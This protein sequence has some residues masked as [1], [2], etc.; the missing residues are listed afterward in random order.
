M[1]AL[2]VRLWDLDARSLWLDE[3]I[4]YWVATAPLAQLPAVVRDV[5]QD[6]PLYS[7]LLH[8]WMKPAVNE[9]WLRLPSVLFGVAG[10]LGVMMIGYRLQGWTSALV[11]GF[12]MSI[13]PT[14]VR[15]SQE[16]GQY[17]LMQG[18]LAWNLVVLVGLVREPSRGG[19]VRWVVLAIAAA[20]T[21]YGAVIAMVIPFA[22]FLFEGGMRRDWLRVR[23]GLGALAVF[24]MA[25]LPLAAWYLPHQL[26]R[27][28]TERALEISTA[29]SLAQ[30]LREVGAS[31][32]QTIAF[33]LTGWPCS[34]TPGWM[35]IVLFAALA[36]FALRRQ[37][38]FAV[39]LTA[40]LVIYAAIGALHL[41]PFGARYSTILTPL[42]VPLVACAI[43]SDAP[44][45]RR[46]GAGLV[47][48]LMCVSCL[49]SLPNRALYSRLY[50]EGKCIW[51]ETED[52]GMVA[53]YWYAHRKPGQPTYV[54]YGAAPA[55]AYYLDRLSG[56]YTPRPADWF[57]ECW[58]GADT[59]A[60]RDGAI[61][62]GRWLRTME[63]EQKV[64]SLFETMGGVPEEFW[65]VAGHSQERE[66]V[67]IGQLLKRQY[68]FVD[69]SVGQDA[70]AVLLWRRAP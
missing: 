66:A 10:V 47:F 5:T 61:F 42:I 43:R 63:P 41:F 30:G 28:P 65:F 57:L 14:A 50:G 12:L 9:A 18:F 21:Y 36:A 52:V 25:I 40:T 1:G 4:E 69:L 11:A 55:F 51:P 22:C 67:V 39:W 26:Q 29:A 23:R 45:T 37:R 48:G 46:V 70:V 35:T 54:Y 16:V 17:A 34:R 20:C 68:E 32:P 3:A 8:L 38:R 31:L 59:P 24:S 53:K 15:Y 33:P 7:F 49:T 60:C 64:A 27:G 6:P 19:F 13:L 44:R 2:A 58:R 62:Y 56:A